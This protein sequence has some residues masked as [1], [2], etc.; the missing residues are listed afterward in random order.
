MGRKVLAIC[1]VL[2]QTANFHIPV[3]SFNDF[4]FNPASAEETARLASSIADAS[5]LILMVSTTGANT[6]FPWH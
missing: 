4:V 6:V 5:R 1:R 3:P 2:Y